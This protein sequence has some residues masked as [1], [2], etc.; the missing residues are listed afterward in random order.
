MG[1]LERRRI[2]DHPHQA[3]RGGVSSMTN[4][5]P[6]D[7]QRVSL[8]QGTPQAA[9]KVTAKPDPA[10][11]KSTTRQKVD[12]EP[13]AVCV[14]IHRERSIHFTQNMFKNIF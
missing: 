8:L 6:R 14:G 9:P 3:S 1:E 5:H 10:Q 4:E 7:R 2:N 11:P 12:F 13:C